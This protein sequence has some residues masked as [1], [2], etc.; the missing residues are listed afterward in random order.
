LFQKGERCLYMENG[1]SALCEVISSRR[2][3]GTVYYT[4]LVLQVTTS[5]ADFG[6][7]L[8]GTV[9]DT[10]ETTDRGSKVVGLFY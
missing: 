7:D 3:V 10:R 4:L 6:Y 8:E 1:A 2:G 5:S 9:I